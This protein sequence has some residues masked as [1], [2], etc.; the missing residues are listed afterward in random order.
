MNDASSRVGG[1]SATTRLR[2]EDFSPHVFRS[3]P[4]QS[5]CESS[6]PLLG[7]GF[8]RA[9]TGAP[10]VRLQPLRE[11]GDR[12]D[13]FAQHSGRTTLS[14]Q[15]LPMSQ[16]RCVTHVSGPDREYL[17]PRERVEL[18]TCRLRICLIFPNLFV[19]SR[20]SLVTSLLF[21]AWSG[22]ELATQFATTR[23]M[24]VVALHSFL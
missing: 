23:D 9:V 2:G 15:V 19:F 14:P 21:W 5:L 20:F 22:T 16:V 11:I 7:H 8:S 13:V 12:R 6:R 10:S 4:L 1:A 3:W 24:L 17:E 18:S